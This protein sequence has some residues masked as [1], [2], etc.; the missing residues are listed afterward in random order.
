MNL[1]KY[2]KESISSGK[3]RVKKRG[4]VSES[5]FG[6][7]LDGIGFYKVSELSSKIKTWEYMICV[8]EEDGKICIDSQFR[9]SGTDYRLLSKFGYD[10]M[11]EEMWLGTVDKRGKETL[12]EHADTQYDIEWLMQSVE[13]MLSGKKDSVTEAISSKNNTRTVPVYTLDDLHDWLDRIGA[14]EVER[15][16]IRPERPEYMFYDEYNGTCFV[17]FLNPATEKRYQVRITMVRNHL[18]EVR[19]LDCSSGRID[20]TIDFT[21]KKEEMSELLN[22]IERMTKES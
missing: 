4:S 6:S 15:F 5:D 9:V 8:D 3:N 17:N 16:T 7:W 19:L 20:T 18:N 10:S 12:K 11:L 1:D 22:T 2:L 14:E 21:Y 13:N